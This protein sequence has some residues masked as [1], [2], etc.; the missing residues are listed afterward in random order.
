MIV[1][2]YSSNCQK[3]L[4]RTTYHRYRPG[5]RGMSL[6]YGPFPDVKEGAGRGG[7][8]VTVA[9]GN[10]VGGGASGR[11]AADGTSAGAAA[12]LSTAC[13]QPG[14]IGN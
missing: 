8:P 14:N 7:L 1:S 2:T 13:G 5:L 9:S 3:L 12:G 11:S 4:Q 6:G 10:Q